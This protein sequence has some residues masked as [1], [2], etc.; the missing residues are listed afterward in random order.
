MKLE[1]KLLRPF[2]VL[3]Y[4]DHVALSVIAA[5]RVAEE[6]TYMRARA[7]THSHVPLTSAGD[8]W[9]DASSGHRFIPSAAARVSPAGGEARRRGVAGA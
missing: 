7:D 3:G 5:V 8:Y 1:P 9:Q 6:R 2:L 4:A